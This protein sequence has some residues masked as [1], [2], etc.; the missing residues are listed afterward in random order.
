M[1]WRRSHGRCALPLDATCRPDPRD[2]VNGFV[3]SDRCAVAQPCCSDFWIS[4]VRLELCLSHVG[5]RTREGTVVLPAPRRSARRVPDRV[6][7]S[8]SRCRTTLVRRRRSAGSMRVAV[9]LKAV[10][11]GMIFGPHFGVRPTVPFNA[12][13]RC[14]LAADPDSWLL[15]V[16][17]SAAQCGA[18]VNPDERRPWSFPGIVE[19][20]LGI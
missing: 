5:E 13:L 20:M 16:H 4:F 11:C 19:E 8:T 2:D 15:D 7:A 14:S 9:H 10:V 12:A 6:S 17:L 18:P 3:E 1:V